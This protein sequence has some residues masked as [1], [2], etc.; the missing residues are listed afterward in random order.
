MSVLPPDTVVGVI[1]AGTMGAGIAHVAAA[2]GHRVILF[3]ESDG[4]AA[5]AIEAIVQRLVRSVERGRIDSEV[6][7]ATEQ[8]LRTASSVDDLAGCG[9]VIEAIVED[10]ETKQQVLARVE[11]LV[12][13]D[14]IIATNTSS[15]SV[16]AI[17][18]GLERP[19]R[20]VGMHFFNPAP[21]MRLVEIVHGAE[22]DP[23]V[24]STVFETVEAWGK[25]AVHA[26]STSA[27]I[28]NRVARPYYGEA[29]R[30][31]TEGVADVA[32]LDAIYT[33]C[34]AW[35]MGPFTLLD[36]IIL[37]VSLAVSKSVFVGTFGDPRFAPSNLQQSLVDAG[38][39][40]RK[41]GRGFYEYGPDVTEPLPVTAPD[42]GLD[43]EVVIHGDPGALGALVD[44]WTMRGI[45]VT[46]VAGDGVISVG[47]IQL[48]LTDGRT[49]TSLV[50][51]GIAP[52][53]T[54]VMDWVHDWNTTS[55]ACIA[56]SSTCSAE[57]LG[58]LVGALQAAGFRVSVVADTPGLVVARTLATLA[59]VAGD[60]VLQ[61]IAT[62][63]AID[64]AMRLGTN[65]PSG[66]LQWTMRVGA[67]RVIAVLD[68]LVAAYG[69][70]RYRAS[71]WLRRVAQDDRLAGARP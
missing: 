25:T 39:L 47:D 31:L 11:K 17:A 2:G 4:V 40:G 29:L 3:D 51:A 33:D 57:S 66:P 12:T 60:T 36:L 67:A 22:T 8:N 58:A 69:E 34:G 49:A 6:A 18:A 56:A 21:V 15:L 45:S 37:D 24:A 23:G 32:T 38:H 71:L 65:Y 46:H 1:G 16:T 14:A 52:V 13:D 50:D 54:V 10:L 44:R 53:N 59:S 9:L 42:H 62:V 28:V 61:G 68:N 43:R 20:C 35:R 48:R 19:E 26:N 27:F 55:R 70:E 30:L 64:T 5:D 63:E 41:T 7:D